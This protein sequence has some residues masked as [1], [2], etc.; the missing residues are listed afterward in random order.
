MTS[1]VEATESKRDQ[2]RERKS[3]KGDGSS[4]C[5]V[6][7]KKKKGKSWAIY[8][9]ISRADKPPIHRSVEWLAK[10]PDLGLDS[11]ETKSGLASDLKM[12]KPL[13]MGLW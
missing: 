1:K 2:K 9:F 11:A 3:Q 7:A 5:D 12:L 4:D 6:V 10:R 13:E 8:H